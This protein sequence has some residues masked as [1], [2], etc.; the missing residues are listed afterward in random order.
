MSV[1]CAAG[2]DPGCTLDGRTALH[3][4]AEEAQ[5]SAA[6]IL[7]AADFSRSLVSVCDAHGRTPL[8]VALLHDHALIS[9]N[10]MTKL[11]AG[12]ALSSSM[13][14]SCAT[15]GALKPAWPTRA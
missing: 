13:R 14:A 6:R 2:A 15:P 4:A 12:G 10:L 5:E 3:A 11:S 7:I 9:S 1:L 8:E